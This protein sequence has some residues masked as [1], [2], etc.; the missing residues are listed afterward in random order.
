MLVEG[1]EFFVF[2]ELPRIAV[3][4][5]VAFEG[6]ARLDQEIMFAVPVS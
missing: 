2:R 6:Q 5:W 3:G 4:S 1:E